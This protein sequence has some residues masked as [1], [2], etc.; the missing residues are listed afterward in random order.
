MGQG[1]SLHDENPHPQHPHLDFHDWH[2]QGMDFLGFGL[3]IPLQLSS[4]QGE[5]STYFCQAFYPIINIKVSTD[6]LENSYQAFK[7]LILKDI[8]PVNNCTTNG[9]NDNSLT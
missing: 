1:S 3:H 9:G 7:L 5:E 2:L 4:S 6:L 8:S